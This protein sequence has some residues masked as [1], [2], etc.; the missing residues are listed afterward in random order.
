MT[1]DD[2]NR[3][4]GEQ[5]YQRLVAWMRQSAMEE[6]TRLPGEHA[7]AHQFSVSRPIL[8]QA[9]ARLRAEGRLYARKGSGTFVQAGTRALPA[10]TFQPL[11]NIPDVQRFLEFRCSVERAMAADAALRRTADDIRAIAAAQPALEHDMATG[12]SGIEADIAL[13]AAIARASGNRFYVAVLD[14]LSEQTRF[15]IKLTR[16]LA[17]RPAADRA[18]DTHSEHARVCD[19]IRNS[20]VEEARQAMDAH[21]QGGIARLFG[22]SADPA[23]A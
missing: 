12:Q 8:R 4:L 1:D 2:A 14:A 9:L 7:L 17:T 22:Q 16:E 23:R 21:L 3:S 20:D 15:S 19:A 13:H 10:M 11:A 5:T 18:R 6:D